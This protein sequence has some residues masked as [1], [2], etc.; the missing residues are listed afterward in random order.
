MRELANFAQE[1]GH[2]FTACLLG[3]PIGAAG[4]TMTSINSGQAWAVFSPL[5]KTAPIALFKACKHGIDGVIAETGIKKI[6]AVAP[7]DDKVACRFMRHLGFPPP[8][9]YLHERIIEWPS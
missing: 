6:Y 4:I 9:L 2:A 7:I 8:T 1:R 5:L 3:N